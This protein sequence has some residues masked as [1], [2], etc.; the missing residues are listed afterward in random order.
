MEKYCSIF[1]VSIF[2]ILNHSI[3]FKSC[4]LMMS[5]STQGRAYFRK[6]LLNRIS[7]GHDTWPTNRHRHGQYFFRNFAHDLEV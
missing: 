1:E 7:F 5:I 6:Y 2:Y 4:G 3:I